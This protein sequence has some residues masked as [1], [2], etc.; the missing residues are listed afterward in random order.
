M[1]VEYRSFFRSVVPEKLLSPCI[2]SFFGQLGYIKSTL[3]IMGDY[4]LI[5]RTKKDPIR[6]YFH[7]FII[8]LEKKVL[9]I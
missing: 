1:S 4:E 6:T 2:P 3:K 8:S 7:F 5:D 9:K